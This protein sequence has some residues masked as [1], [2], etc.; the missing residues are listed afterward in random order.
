ME[1]PYPPRSAP[2]RMAFS[3]RVVKAMTVRGRF[4]NTLRRSKRWLDDSRT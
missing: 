1:E 4:N 2:F 3:S